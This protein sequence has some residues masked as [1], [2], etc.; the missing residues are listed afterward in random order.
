MSERIE[1]GEFIEREKQLPPEDRPGSVAEDATGRAQEDLFATPL[2]TPAADY[3]VRSVY[4]SR[5]V[6]GYDFNITAQSGAGEIGTSSFTATFVVRQ[7]FVAVLRR[8]SHFFTGT[9]PP[10]MERSEAL[11]S[12]TRNGADV[13]DNVDVPVGLYSDDIWQGFVIADEGDTLG[14]TLELQGGLVADELQVHFYGNYLLKTGRAYNYEI[15]NPVGGARGCAPSPV[16]LAPTAPRTVVIREPAPPQRTVR[17]V[18]RETV[19]RVIA[20]PPPPT[21]TRVLRARSGPNSGGPSSGAK[22]GR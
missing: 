9:L 17:E 16:M 15:A 14:V 8:L 21:Q 19:S 6:N 5:P 10:I 22:K 1:G 12:I 7:G 4:D 3:D 20:P 13:L 11:L 2:G 18:I